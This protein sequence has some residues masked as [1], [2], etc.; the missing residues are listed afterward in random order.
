M[1][2]IKNTL[3]KHTIK[4]FVG[5]STRSVKNVIHPNPEPIVGEEELQKLLKLSGLNES[6]VSK[7]SLI[8]SLNLQLSFI[9]SLYGPNEMVSKSNNDNIFRLLRPDNRPE[10]PL[11]LKALQAQIER[12]DNEIDPEKG[13]V[14]F[15]HNGFFVIKY[16]IPQ[17]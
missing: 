15:S 17:D 4:H 13:E 9:K 11:T 2:S 12:V 1:S 16:K 5:H 3:N 8:D 6:A 10:P 14:G 7:Q